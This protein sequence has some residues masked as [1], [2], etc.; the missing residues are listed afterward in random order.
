L[1]LFQRAPAQKHTFS[2]LR[3]TLGIAK[4]QGA[5]LREILNRL[6]N[7]GDLKREK[8]RYILVERT[9][10]PPSPD[11]AL[12]KSGRSPTAQAQSKRPR[13]KAPPAAPVQS[14]QAGRE[15]VF[16][17]TRQGFGFVEIPGADEDLFIPAQHIGGALNEDT[18]RVEPLPPRGRKR[19]AYQVAE[20]TARKR[21]LVR[22]NV[23]VDFNGVWLLPLNDRIPHVHLPEG[24]A[25]GEFPEHHIVEVEITAYPRHPEEAPEGRITRILDDPGGHPTVMVEH[26][27]SD[28]GLEDGF[29]P[30]SEREMAGIAKAQAPPAWAGKGAGKDAGRDAGRGAGNRRKDL[31]GLPFV[32]IDGEDAKDFDDAVCLETGPGGGRRL[33]VAI[34]DVAEY[35]RPGSAIDRDAYA[36]G[37][38]VYLPGRVLPMLPGGLSNELC[39]L[40]PDEDRLALTCEMEFDPQGE[41][42][43]Y[44]LYESLIRSQARLTYGGVEEY[45]AEA[46][47]GG[48]PRK[49]PRKILSMLTRMRKLAEQLRTRRDARGALDFSFGETRFD[50]DPQGNLVGLREVFATEATRLIEQFMVEANETAAAHC[51]AN[52]LP[53]LYRNHEPPPRE[54]LEALPEVLWN[55]GIAI[56]QTRLDSPQGIKA[57]LQLAASH[58]NREQVELTILKAMSQATYREHNEGHFALSAP[59]YTHFTSPIR[60]YPDL[61][62]H[63]AIKGSLMK[64]GRKSG[65]PPD[66][67]YRLS[68]RER[69]AAEAEG[70]V[71][72]LY[73]VIHME[74]RLGQTFSATVIGQGKDGLWMRLRD[75]PVEGLL[76][77]PE[78]PLAGKGGKSSEQYSGQKSAQE[79]R[80]HRSRG[81]GKSQETP[82]GTRL[83]VSLTRAD[84]L[85][86]KL[87]FAFVRWRWKKE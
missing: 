68:T 31:R 53:I 40:K 47:S 14:S 66:C 64:R 56:K 52:G 59:I 87:E 21:R 18:V 46:D 22:G 48:L 54:Q 61:L 37:T 29:S 32:T 16:R 62:A 81:R 50:L 74:S 5:K 75:E 12:A 2:E 67:G 72:R 45:F 27:L 19:G 55:F 33:Y 25:P 13:K 69:T 41:R 60:R 78:I 76:P 4:S 70:R 71:N 35:V 84:R 34:A 49:L 51:G 30:E 24:F 28:T 39:S 82:V 65:L 26:I 63:R 58:P 17:A 6:V 20:I 80:G 3:S 7:K 85:A 36:K 1:S 8:H 57:L 44:R 79:T 43:G 11:A 73:K 42:T 38:S 77:H 10:S 9:V 83:T 86:Q 15:G 23:E